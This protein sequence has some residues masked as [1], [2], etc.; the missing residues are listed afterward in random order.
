MGKRMEDGRSFTHS[1]SLESRQGVSF[2]ETRS[3]TD[4]LPPCLEL[5][6]WGRGISQGPARSGPGS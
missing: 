1:H 4:H 6:R 5:L 2:H 3:H